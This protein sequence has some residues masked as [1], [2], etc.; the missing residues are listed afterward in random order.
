M[1]AMFNFA[2]LILS[3]LVA[4][5]ITGE[6]ILSASIEPLRGIDESVMFTEN[7][8]VTFIFSTREQ[9]RTEL[10]NIT[11]IDPQNIE[12]SWQK[13]FGGHDQSGVFVDDF[14]V[15]TPKSSGIHQIK[16]SNADFNTDIKLVSGMTHPSE[17]PLYFKTLIISLV[18]LI[19]G[20]MLFG[21]SKRRVPLIPGLPIPIYRTV[22]SG[23]MRRFTAFQALVS[24]SA[25]L[26]IVYNVA[27]Q[28][29]PINI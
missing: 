17:Q 10:L 16:I 14:T 29:C 26:Y 11:I 12:Y 15:F 1:V 20:A 21:A 22:T 2:F 18:L 6:E 7:E 28:A 9:I 5:S 4:G 25:S 3:V 24:L 8:P 19:I 27:F 13:G 23:K